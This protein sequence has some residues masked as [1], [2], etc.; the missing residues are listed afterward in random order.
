MNEILDQSFDFEF[1]KIKNLTWFPWVGKDYKDAPYK[2]LIIGES[3]YATN[4]KEYDKEADEAFKQDK[5]TIRELSDNA[6]KGNGKKF[7]LNQ[8]PLFIGKYGGLNQLYAKIAFYDFIQRPAHAVSGD[9]KNPDF[10]NGWKCWYELVKVLQP[11][12]CIF[13]GLSIKKQFPEF[14]QQ[15]GVDPQW[16]DIKESDFYNLGKRIFPIKGCFVIEDHEI[17]MLFI[18]HPSRMT[19]IT[20]WHDFLKQQIPEAIEWLTA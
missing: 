17:N 7:Y 3:L 2:V 4:E 11:D 13:C 9:I 8:S 20:Q 15:L 6:I 18:Q 10:M 1:D 12:I 5:N 19:D 16:K 14:S